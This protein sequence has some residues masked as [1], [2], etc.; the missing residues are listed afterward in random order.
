M[1]VGDWRR[2]LRVRLGPSLT[3]P[4]RTVAYASGSDR[5]LRVR[6]GPSLTRPARTVAYASRS[7]RRLRVR[8]GPSLTRP[9]RTVAYASA[10]D[11]RLRVRLGPSLTRP[12]RTVA[13]WWGPAMPF[14][15]ALTTEPNSRAAF[16][17]LCQ[18]AA[19]ALQ[20]PA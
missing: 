5:R 13:L 19:A 14:A 12:A 10:S 1:R 17:D 6:L 15:S 2:R 20:G 3:R 9:A 11:R 18:R 4:A 16:D 7:D 8:L